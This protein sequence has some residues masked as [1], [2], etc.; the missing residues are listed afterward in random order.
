MA[1]GYLSLI[2]KNLIIAVAIAILFFYF[3]REKCEDFL[4]CNASCTRVDFK[5]GKCYPPLYQFC[6]CET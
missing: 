5:G 3:C 2:T 4:D 6:C 1:R